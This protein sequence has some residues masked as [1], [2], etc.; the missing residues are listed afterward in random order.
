MVAVTAGCGVIEHGAAFFIGIVAGWVYIASDFALIKYQ[1]D[2][3]VSA[4]PVHLA[5]G[6]WGVVAVGLFASPERLVA[7]Y[8]VYSHPGCIYAPLSNNLLP[9]QLVGVIAIIAWTFVTMVPYFM[10]LDYMGWFRVNELEEIIGLDATYGRV[11]HSHFDEE[12]SFLN[13]EEIRRAAYRQRFKERKQIQDS[14]PVEEKSA[15]QMLKDY[16]ENAEKKRVG[17]VPFRSGRRR[18]NRRVT[19]Q[20]N[21]KSDDN[22]QPPPIDN[23]EAVIDV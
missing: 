18:L 22:E 20:E 11:Q 7:A 1:L 2:D 5:N 14:Q 16:V 17:R 13:N 23:E 12:N 6:V 8:G 3:A 4:I 19:I 9:A 21:K 15:K 10:F